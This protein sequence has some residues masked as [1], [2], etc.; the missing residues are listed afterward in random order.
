[1]VRVNHGL[2]A[3]IGGG[4]NMLQSTAG[5]LKSGPVVVCAK[6]PATAYDQSYATM[7]PDDVPPSKVQLSVRPP[8]DISQ[9]SVSVGPVTPNLA[10]ATDGFVTDR[11]ADAVAPPYDPVIVAEAPPPPGRVEIEKIAPVAP[12]PTVTLAGMITGPVLDNSTTAPPAGAAAVSV[13][14]PVTAFPSTTLEALSE[15]AARAVVRAVTVSAPD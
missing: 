13:A 7:F 1:M 6:V 3:G 2:P 5:F 11:T 8:F 12:A 9:V 14:V 15:I 4:G 10:V